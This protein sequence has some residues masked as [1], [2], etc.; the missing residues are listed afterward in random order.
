MAV[1]VEA[2]VGTVL[3]AVL[4]LACEHDPVD[5]FTE[6]YGPFE[7]CGELVY[8]F[9]GCPAQAPEA[10]TCMENA[11]ATCKP[12]QLRQ[13]FPRFDAPDDRVDLFV[14]EDRG[15]CVVLEM[16]L[17]GRGAFTRRNCAG[18][19]RTVTDSGCARLLPTGCDEEPAP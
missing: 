9:S 10:L 13:Y 12:S 15:T 1:F 8:D 7:R 5:T 11:L 6:A 18:F 16:T 19:E 4:L 17:E 14:L 2:A 3:A